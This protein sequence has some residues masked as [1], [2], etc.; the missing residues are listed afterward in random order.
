MAKFNSKNCYYLK[1]REAIVTTKP[2]KSWLKM[3]EQRAR[4]AQKAGKTKSLLNSFLSIQVL[5][6][7]LAFISLPL[8]LG[9]NLLPWRVG[10]AMLLSKILVDAISLIVSEQFYQKKF[11]RK[12]FIICFL[13]YP[14]MVIQIAIWSLKKNHWHGRQVD[15]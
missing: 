15:V 7:N 6:M 4:W 2:K 12:S 10:F 8:W 13:I 11:W 3:I 5:L 14:I 1:S 9:F